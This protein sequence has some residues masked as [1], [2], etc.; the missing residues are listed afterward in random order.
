MATM[1]TAAE[2]R[3]LPIRKKKAETGQKNIKI[4]MFFPTLG[5]N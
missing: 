2:N 4:T 1:L 5:V 3:V